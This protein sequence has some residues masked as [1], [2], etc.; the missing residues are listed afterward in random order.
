MVFIEIDPGQAYY[1]KSLKFFHAEIKKDLNNLD[2]LVVLKF[3]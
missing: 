1:F 2:R 3:R